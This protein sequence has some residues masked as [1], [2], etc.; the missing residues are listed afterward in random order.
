MPTSQPASPALIRESSAVDHDQ[1][2]SQRKEVAGPQVALGNRPSG[3]GKSRTPRHL[4]LPQGDRM[5]TAAVRQATSHHYAVSA[6]TA[7]AR[8]D[9]H[10]SSSIDIWLVIVLICTVMIALL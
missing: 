8:R 4:A 7:R 9:R 5:K 2:S 1:P 6:E 3:A 10:S